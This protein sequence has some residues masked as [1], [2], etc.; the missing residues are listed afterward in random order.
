MLHFLMVLRCWDQ[1]LL[2]SWGHTKREPSS[3]PC[4]VEGRVH[5]VVAS[6]VLVGG[7]CATV[8]MRAS[9]GA[10]MREGL[11]G[12]EGFLGGAGLFG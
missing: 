6:R 2:D 7:G 12:V 4:R 11:E 1:Q 5:K 8:A 10:G 9:V 3:I